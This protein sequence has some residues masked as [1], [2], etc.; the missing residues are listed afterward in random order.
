MKISKSNVFLVEVEDQ[1]AIIDRSAGL[2]H[3]VDADNAKQWEAGNDV[4]VQST[5]KT[6]IAAGSGD[7]G[8]NSA[9]GGFDNVSDSEVPSG[10]L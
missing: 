5:S 9:G 7:N 8:G 6:V 2:I 4:T 3:I 10:E 1:F